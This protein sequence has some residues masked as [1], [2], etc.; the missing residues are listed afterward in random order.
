M[1]C[2]IRIVDGEHI[3]KEVSMKLTWD[4]GEDEGE[5]EEP[6]GDPIEEVGRFIEDEVLTPDEEEDDDG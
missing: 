4:P 2:G 6:L 3:S 5:E 1:V